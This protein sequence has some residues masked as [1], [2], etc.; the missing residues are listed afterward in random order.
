MDVGDE[1]RASPTDMHKPGEVK[2]SI[3]AWTQEFSECK[4]HH[5]LSNM[6]AEPITRSATT[7]SKG[8]MFNEAEENHKR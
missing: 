3:N 5:R 2:I 7:T 4:S 1:L 8:G 6:A